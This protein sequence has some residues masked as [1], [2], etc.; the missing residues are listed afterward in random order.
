MGQGNDDAQP[1][2][3]SRAQVLKDL[4]AAGLLRHLDQQPKKMPVFEP[5]TGVV[6]PFRRPAPVP[7]PKIEA[8][9]RMAVL[10]YVLVAAIIALVYFGIVTLP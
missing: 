3:K 9:R 10:A 6:L 5:R 1:A 8:K 7:Q 4:E 2:G